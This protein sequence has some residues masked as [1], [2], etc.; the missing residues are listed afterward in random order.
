MIDLQREPKTYRVATPSTE[1]CT[2]FDRS[3]LLAMRAAR[4]ERYW[5]HGDVITVFAGA[6]DTRGS[7]CFFETRVLSPGLSCVRPHAH[8][9]QDETTGVRSG[10]F[11]FIVAGVRLMPRPGDL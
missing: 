8:M 11:E 5:I 1:A 7:H 3:D 4:R 6:E 9:S 2:F 10:R